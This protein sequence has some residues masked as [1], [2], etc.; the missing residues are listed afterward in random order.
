MPGKWFAASL[1]CILL[2]VLGCQT[3]PPLPPPTPPTPPPSTP[4][5]FAY[6]LR[7]GDTLFSLGERFGVPWQEL[8]RE[9]GIQRPQDLPVGTLL[10]IP[11]L[12]GVEVPELKLP[13]AAPPR[14]EARRLAVPRRDLHKGRPTAKLWWPTRGRLVRRSGD[15]VRGLPEKGI[16]IAAPAGTEAYAVAA[17][18]VITC[19][20]PESGS[21]SAWGNV[22]ALSHAGGMVSWYAHL[23][24]IF[25][26]K[27]ARV[28]K[29]QVIGTVGSSGA[30]E[31][32]ELAFRLFRNE[33]QVDPE[34]LLP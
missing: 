25:V 12:P 17:G 10:L 18:S 27:G 32:P 4:D 2:G 7:K 19:I 23:D 9:N 24:R 13:E 21:E 31:R 29:G 28:D 15:L 16:G 22:L 11:R 34:S 30:V 26:A 6:H 3:P 14:A 33:R 20:R 5:Y 1:V 8:A